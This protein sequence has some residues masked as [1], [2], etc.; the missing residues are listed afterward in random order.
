MKNIIIITAAVLISINTY[1][2]IKLTSKLQ[3]NFKIV[4]INENTT[5]Y[6]TVN[7]K[8]NT[9][10][11]FNLDETLWKTVKLVISED[12]FLDKILHISTDKIN[13]DGQVEIVY[14]TYKETYSDVFDNVESIVYENYNLVIINEEG[15][16]L[17]N[18]KGGI[19]FNIL[20]NSD[21]SDIILINTVI[22]DEFVHDKGTSVFTIN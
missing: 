21:A 15:D 1:S 14:T 11:F 19:S 16:E 12:V 5:K 9:V 17:L 2:Q 4:K 18:V 8:N 13:K 7:F 10:N 3:S 20:N 6:Y 22:N